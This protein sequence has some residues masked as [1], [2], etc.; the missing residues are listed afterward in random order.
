MA[1]RRLKKVFLWIILILVAANVLIFITGN[2]HVYKALVY[3]FANID[4]YEIFPNRKI[5]PSSPSPWPIHKNCM[6]SISPL[7]KNRLKEL[8]TIAFVIIK[9][10]SICYEEY[11][12]DYG[13]DSYS[14]SFSMAK[15]YVSALTGI[16]LKE[17]KIKSLDQPVAD[18]LPEFET[19]PE[20]QIRIRH[21]LT[22]SSGLNW[23]ESYIDPFSVTTKAYYGDDL[24]STIK[25]L[26][27]VDVP[28]I[29]F[30]YKSGDTQILSFVL[31][32]AT[33]KTVSEYLEEKIWGPL[34]AESPALWSLDKEGG[35][36]KAYCCLN[37]NARDFARFGRL[38][39][40]QGN[41]N[42]KQIIDSAYVKESVTPIMLVDQDEQD[43]KVDFYGFSW[44]I[45]PDYKGQ[46]IFYARGILGQYIIVIPELDLIMV[47][48][49][50]QR[51]E[52]VGNHYEEVFLMIDEANRI[53]ART[54]E[55]KGIEDKAA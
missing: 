23:D 6:D 53:F 9:A 30:R 13:P 50:K 54:Q 10:D 32:K 25:G 51:G 12:D 24:K 18:F 27:A 3:N 34:G 39:L 1:G 49:G 11:W 26:K 44:W 16:A 15:S 35:F 17:G 40:R 2:K 21:L 29:Y 46:E 45:I 33:G 5:S 41:W 36:E 8:E 43:E 38:F 7:L 22:M 52:I 47:R 48:L 55:E 42:G 14:N 20:N 4:D 37:S 31:E 28:G 19:Y